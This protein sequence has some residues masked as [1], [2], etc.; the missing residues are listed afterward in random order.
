MGLE[1]G[2]GGCDCRQVWVLGVG[3]GCNCG[4][5]WV[6]RGGIVTVVRY[7]SGEGGL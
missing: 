1:R 2:G 5:V 4:W 3:D 7:G 6:W